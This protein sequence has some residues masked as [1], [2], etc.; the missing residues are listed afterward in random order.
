MLNKQPGTNE[1]SR[2]SEKVLKKNKKGKMKPFVQYYDYW[3]DSNLECIKALGVDRLP[4]GELQTHR[5][6][7]YQDRFL[8]ETV[9]VDGF[10][11]EVR[12]YLFFCPHCAKAHR[13]AIHFA[14]SVN[15]LPLRSILQADVF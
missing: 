2:I 9:L 15:R 12:C 4:N 10:E 1:V 14:P 11:E 7:V 13:P 8:D 6:L 3:L 5:K